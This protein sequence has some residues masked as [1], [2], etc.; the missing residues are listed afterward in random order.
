MLNYAYQIWRRYKAYLLIIFVAMVAW[1]V[2][3]FPICLINQ[4]N[5]YQQSTEYYDSIY[6][7]CAIRGPIWAIYWLGWLTFSHIESIALVITAIATWAIARFT[8]ALRQ[9]T[10]A[11]HR[12]RI[13]IK[14]VWLA[15]EILDDGPLSINVLL[16]NIGD[17]PA[18]LN[19]AAIAIRVIA[20]DVQLPPNIQYRNLSVAHYNPIGL[21]FTLQLDITTDR[22]ISYS[23]AI[24][25]RGETLSLYC[26]GAIEYLDMNN[27]PRIRRTNFCRVLTVPAE[28]RV[29]NDFYRFRVVDDPDY[30]YED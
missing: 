1:W 25:I 10:T 12:P 19:N 11:T 23:E 15:N 26:I 22:V 6:K 20:S 27:P 5:P 29:D 7:I 17:I 3:S 2:L 30:E 21:G 9:A 4:T 8:L 14:H 28:R 18:R 16:V 13:R 24:D